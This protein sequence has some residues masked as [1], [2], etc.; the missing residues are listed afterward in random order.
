[1]YPGSPKKNNGTGPVRSKL[2]V[3]AMDP[4]LKNPPGIKIIKK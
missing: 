2:N 3:D 1:M 4:R